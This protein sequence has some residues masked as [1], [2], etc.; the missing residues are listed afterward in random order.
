MSAATTVRP[1][2][3]TV[4]TL[5][6]IKMLVPHSMV[7]QGAHTTLLQ[8]ITNDEKILAPQTAAQNAREVS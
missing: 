8:H 4:I 2:P 7:P 1:P 6:C 5:K 3:L